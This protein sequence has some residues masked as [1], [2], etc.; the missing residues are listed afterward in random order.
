M[1][2][3][4]YMSNT[5]VYRDPLIIRK[6]ENENN[7]PSLINE[8]SISDKIKIGNVHNNTVSGIRYKTDTM[9]FFAYLEKS[10]K[11]KNYV[12]FKFDDNSSLIIFTKDDTCSQ[13]EKNNSDLHFMFK[14]TSLNINGVVEPKYESDT[15]SSPFDLKNIINNK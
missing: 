10:I 5:N 8:R 12:E 9:Y 15:F 4:N 1:G 7:L 2:N 11:E 14:S 6:S 3:T 13:K